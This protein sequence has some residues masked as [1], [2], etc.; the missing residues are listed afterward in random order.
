[1]IK[2][3]DLYGRYPHGGHAA[4]YKGEKL[5][6]QVRPRPA[7]TALARGD[8]ASSLAHMALNAMI[9]QRFVK[10][11]RVHGYPQGLIIGL[12]LRPPAKQTI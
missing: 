12:P 1:M 8:F 9:V 11:S 3:F 10:R 7:V 6:L 4:V 2:R 5:A